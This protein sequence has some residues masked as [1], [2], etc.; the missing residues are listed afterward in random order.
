[1]KRQYLLRQDIHIVS[2]EFVLFLARNVMFAR[3]FFSVN[4]HVPGRGVSGNVT[5]PCRGDWAGRTGACRL[6]GRANPTRTT[7]RCPNEPGA[8]TARPNPTGCGLSPLIRT[9]PSA[10]EPNEPGERRAG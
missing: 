5:L 8:P 9:N 6:T 7:R 3:H 10:R 2:R 4:F 1:M